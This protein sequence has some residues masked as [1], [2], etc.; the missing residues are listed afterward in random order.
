MKKLR[1]IT[2]TAAVLLVSLS[3]CQR[4]EPVIR[5]NTSDSET[6]E[7]VI[8][9]ESPVLRYLGQASI[10]IVT[11]E[12]KVI[13]IDP[14]AGE[15]EDYAL[16]ADLILVT[17][18]HF[19]HNAVEKV[20]NRNTGCRIITQEES[21][22]GKEHVEFDLGYVTV[23]PVEAGYNSMHDVSNSVGYVLTFSNEKSVYVTGDTSKTEQMASMSEM[24]IDYAFYCC[25]GVYNMGLEE[26]AECAR[27]VGA[28]HNIP[29]H[30][31]TE[32]RDDMFDA[33]LAEQFD[34]PNRLIVAAG[35]EINVE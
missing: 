26:A 33:M 13:Y 18:A 34:A 31:T 22:Q 5:E 16:A 12:D 25:D 29:Y 35:E 3:A 20:A 14:Y 28:K 27:L 15:E 23:E 24:K 11:P 21:I 8:S 30:N 4:K 2:V 17:H 6:K 7:S 9:S 32:N 19:D 10:R 1:N